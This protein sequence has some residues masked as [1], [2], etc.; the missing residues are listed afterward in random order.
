MRTYTVMLL[1]PDYMQDGNGHD[2]YTHSCRARNAKAAVVESQLV[3]SASN[4]DVDPSCFAVL[5]VMHGTV[6]F[7]EHF[8]C[9]LE[10]YD[11]GTT[12]GETRKK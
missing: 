3:A 9:E 5:A 12:K 10:D 6:K 11:Q 8:D 7:V 1:Y 4:D 2:T